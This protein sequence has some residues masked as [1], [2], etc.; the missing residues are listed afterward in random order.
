MKDHLRKSALLLPTIAALALTACQPPK[1]DQPA[2]EPPAAPAPA[3]QASP[4]ASPAP[5]QPAAPTPETP[6]ISTPSATPAPDQPAAPAPTPQ[7]PLL[8]PL[9]PEARFET[10]PSGDEIFGDPLLRETFESGWQTWDGWN[11]ATKSFSGELPAG[12]RFRPVHDKAEVRGKVQRLTGDVPEGESA[13]RIHV[14]HLQG[15]YADL[16]VDQLVPANRYTRIAVLLRSGSTMQIAVGM[17]ASDAEGGNGVWIQRRIGVTAEWQEYVFV[18]PPQRTADNTMRFFIRIEQNGILDIDNL[19]IWSLD[20]EE[21]NTGLVSPQTNGFANTSFPGGLPGGWGVHGTI[22]AGPDPQTLGPSGL[23]AFRMTTGYRANLVSAPLRIPGNNRYQLSFAAKG[24]KDGQ[25]VEVSFGPPEKLTTQKVTLTPE[26]KD[27]ALTFRPDIPTSGF[28]IARFRTGNT[29]WLDQLRIAEGTPSGFAREFPAEVTAVPT[30]S[31]GVF[32]GEEIGVSVTVIGDIPPGAKLVGSME[33]MLRRKTD[34]EATA[35]EALPQ[36]TLTLQPQLP[37]HAPYGTFRL[38]LRVEDA[39]G[40][41]LSAWSEVVFHHVRPARKLGE[42]APNSPFGIHI[43]GTRAQAAMAKKLGFNWMRAHDGS[44]EM[45][46]WYNL[47]RERGIFDFRR[48]DAAVDAVRAEKLEILGLLDSAPTFAS[49]WD[50]ATKTEKYYEDA[51]WVPKNLKAWKNYVQ[52]TVAHFAGRI[53]DWEVWNEPYVGKFFNKSYDAAA[54]RKIQG[55]PEDYIPLLQTAYENAKAANPQARIF[56]A[57]GPYYRPDKTWHQ[58]TAEL[59]AGDSADAISFHVYNTRKLGAPDDLIASKAAEYRQGHRLS[60]APLWNTEGGP[61]A[62]V[63]HFY[64]HLPPFDAADRATAIADHVVRFFVSHLA[65][66]VQ[67][68]FLYTFHSWGSWKNEWTMMAHDGTLPPHASA[69]SNLF[70]H[71]ED[72]KFVNYAKLPENRGWIARFDRPDGNTVLVLLPDAPLVPPPGALD[73]YGNPLHPDGPLTANVA[74]LT[75]PSGEA[76]AAIA[77]LGGQ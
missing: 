7:A 38:E 74:Y 61:G 31:Y 77:R 65:A 21:F 35:L 20:G 71:L 60:D 46:K 27:Y 19:R 2:D 56:W 9:P 34:L 15:A 6:Q 13:L 5:D 30:A 12:Y 64:R 42:F 37:S 51:L 54:K 25:V 26:W 75:V 49:Y 52:Q 10:P 29:I 48:A 45:T 41:P 63:N 23:P 47:E 16:I 18:V 62:S 14:E 4:S 43:L 76:D 3:E 73:L 32:D 58:R 22:E 17:F 67:K 69:L 72:S 66:N 40:Q 55:T 39:S 53:N 28:M 44:N 59:G 70:W 68:F 1:A 50:E 57:T 8:P 33:D 24:A 36:Q 11:S